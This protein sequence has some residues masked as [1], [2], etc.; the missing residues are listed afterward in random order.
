MTAMSRF[1]GIWK[2]CLGAGLAAL[3]LASAHVPV[4]AA[5][6]ALPVPGTTIYPGDVITDGMLQDRQFAVNAVIRVPVVDSRDGLVGRVA[7]KTLLPG[8]PIPLASV[9]EPYT[10]LQGKAAPITYRSGALTITS[11]AI[12]L[13]SGSVGEIISARN[14]DSGT[15]VRGVIEANGC[16]RVGLP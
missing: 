16:I 1:V 10:V 5:G 11:Q 14:V 3:L 7:R 8:Y 13:Q 15:V 9:R 12:A 2:L 4:A 6:R